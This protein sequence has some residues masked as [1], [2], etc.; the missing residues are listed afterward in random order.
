MATA[1]ATVLGTV[2]TAAPAHAVL[3]AGQVAVAVAG[4]DTSDKVM[5]SILSSPLFNNT[6][7]TVNGAPT[8]V[9]AYNIPAF[10]PAGTPFVVPGDGFGCSADVSW[11][12]DPLGPGASSPPTKGISPFGSSSGRNYL[13]EET[14]GTGP[15]PAPVVTGTDFACIDVARSSSAPRVIGTGGS[16][17]SASFKYTAFALDAQSWATTSIKAP[18]EMTQAE[19][20][21]IFDCTITDWGQIGG[22]PGVIQR[23]FPQSGSGTQAFFISDL[24]LNK[25]SSYLPPAASTVPGCPSDAIFVEENNGSLILDDHVDSAIVAY[26]SAVWAFQESNRT[27]PTIDIRKDIRMGGITTAAPEVVITRSPVAWSGVDVQYSLDNSP[28]GIVKEENSKL[29]DSTPAYPGIR[30]IFNVLDTVDN[31]PGYQAAF[32]LFSFD[33]VSGGSAGNK[34]CAATGP[35]GSARAF[36]R[37]AIVSNGYLPLNTTGGNPAANIPGSTCRKYVPTGAANGAPGN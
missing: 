25:T 17:D 13:R 32:E 5:G 18:A 11:V 26:S 21:A 9:R 28:T 12:R 31:R 24:L 15:Q 29:V 37:G 34:L 14:D 35:S 7:L 33:N 1:L 23:Y 6:T 8:T 20:T 16:N 4:S 10:P 27:N 36:A 3:P 19:L 22:V 2:A 30:Y